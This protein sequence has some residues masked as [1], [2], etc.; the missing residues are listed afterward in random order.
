MFTNIFHCKTL[1]N[2]PNLQFW[3]EYICTI[4]QQA[5]KKNIFRHKTEKHLQDLF[6]MPT[7]SQT[8]WIAAEPIRSLFHEGNQ[9]FFDKHMSPASTYQ[10]S[11]SFLHSY[12]FVH[13]YM[14]TFIG[15]SLVF[16]KYIYHMFSSKINNSNAS[17]FQ[18]HNNVVEIHKTLNPIG[19][20]NP[21]SSELKANWVTTVPIQLG[22]PNPIFLVFLKTD[23]K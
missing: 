13:M 15:A 17:R 10:G 18:K 7:T 2:F 19:D 8:S 11:R 3:S 12:L 4:W 23:E 21:Q 20:L 1:Q 14:H 22:Q 6:V 16:S 5:K 9:I